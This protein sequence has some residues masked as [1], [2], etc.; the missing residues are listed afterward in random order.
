MSVTFIT[1]LGEMKAEIFCDTMPRASEN[2]LAL[3]ASDY[4]NGTIFHRSM[5][6]FMIQGGDPTGTGKGGQ[7]IW[8]EPFPDEFHQEHRHDRRGIL[9]MANNSLDSNGSQFFITYAAQPHLNNKYTI[10]GMIIDGFEVLDAMERIAVGKK[11]RPLVDIVIEK[12]IIHANP[13]ADRS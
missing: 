4:Y 12:I 3:C 13:I 6:G 2:F 8:G 7:S 5:K 1:S 11:N 10:F 9:S